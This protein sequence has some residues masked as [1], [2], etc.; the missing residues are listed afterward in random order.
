[1]GAMAWGVKMLVCHNILGW[2]FFLIETYD[3]ALFSGGDQDSVQSVAR[4]ICV[5]AR[6]KIHRSFPIEQT[7]AA[8]TV[9]A[10]SANMIALPLNV[11]HAT[12]QIFYATD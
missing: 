9:N 5:L 11:N 10:V 4:K 2:C 1:M 7:H 3:W 12:T 8:F 6:F